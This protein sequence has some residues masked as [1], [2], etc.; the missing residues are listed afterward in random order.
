M[1]GFS[2]Y[3]NNGF[4]DHGLPRMPFSGGPWPKLPD[5]I[6]IHGEGNPEEIET[7]YWDIDTSVFDGD[8]ANAF[9][10]LD[11][12]PD[13]DDNAGV[14]IF[15]GPDGEIDY[16]APG[17]DPLGWVTGEEDTTFTAGEDD[18]EIVDAEV[19]DFNDLPPHI[20]AAL[21]ATSLV[22]DL[23][24]TGAVPSF[25]PAMPAEFEDIPRAELVA[26][27]PEIDDLYTRLQDRLV[28]APYD[29][30]GGYFA[31]IDTPSGSAIVHD[32]TRGHAGQV[33]AFLDAEANGARFDEA[34]WAAGLL[35]N[36][37]GILSISIQD[38]RIDD[39][40]TNET[41]HY[42]VARPCDLDPTDDG[43]GEFMADTLAEQAPDV[44]MQS[45]RPVMF[46][47]TADEP[48]IIITNTQHDTVLHELYTMLMDDG[49]EKGR[50]GL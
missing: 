32:V 22:E 39:L 28:H 35:K 44:T 27:A 17:E 7:S 36:H 43:L 12:D 47:L 40:A 25:T 8:A 18:S 21:G 19:V 4:D 26:P 9:T 38:G 3:E 49:E 16:V 45:D 6:V 42:M 24:D 10:D 41:N 11:T 31:E 5:D 34:Q 13:Y 37:T 50:E 30:E 2:R 1:D 33:D 15:F 23:D 29:E 20:Q 48:T 14:G 46:S